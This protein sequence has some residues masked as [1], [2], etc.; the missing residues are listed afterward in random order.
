MIFMKHI[1]MYSEGYVVSWAL[2]MGVQCECCGLVFACGE[3]GINIRQ[4]AYRA[5]NRTDSSV[6]SY[7][8]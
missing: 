1:I 6:A 7:L 8:Y 2:H 5:S 4:Y 3:V